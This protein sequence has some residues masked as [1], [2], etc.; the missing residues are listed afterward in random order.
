M[1]D[2]FALSAA[3]GNAC[4]PLRIAAVC[5]FKDYLPSLLF[6]ASQL[7]LSFLFL[8]FQRDSFWFHLFF[9]SRSYELR[10]A[11]AHALQ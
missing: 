4:I 10:M 5:A 2:E 9:Q 11:S 1:D 3:Q 6:A 8:N 7:S